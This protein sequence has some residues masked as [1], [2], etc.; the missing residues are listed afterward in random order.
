[1]KLANLLTAEDSARND[2]VRAFYNNR[3][4]FLGLCIVTIIAILAA[5][6]PFLTPYDPYSMNLELRNLGPS[7]EHWAGTDHYGR[8]LMTRILYGARISLIIGLI[9]AFL[10]TCIGSVLGVVSGFYGGKVDF[11]IMR[12]AD[13]VLAFPSILLAMAI[14]YTLGATLINIFIALSIVGWATTSRIVRSQTLSIK[15]KEFVEAARAIGVSK[16]KIIFRHI[17]PNCMPNIVVVFTM[18]IPA[19]IMQEATLS[20]LGVGVQPPTP[21]WGLLVSQ[22]KE[23]IF[24]APWV[25]IAPGVAILILVMAF[26]FMGDG[27]RDA[28]D[29]Y[30]KD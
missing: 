22:G 19:A 20:F 15:E 7:W 23:Y 6:A 9:P 24:S 27:F 10:S 16:S 12:L 17:L 26:N 30:M 3:A 1:M 5:S 14:M 28:I 4:A 11:W 18:S 29:P 21:S 2:L 13:I 25:A 8:D